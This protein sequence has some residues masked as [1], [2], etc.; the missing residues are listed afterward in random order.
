MSVSVSI[1]IDIPG[2]T[3]TAAAET[4]AQAE[5]LLRT[6]D[7]VLD[8]VGS[9][10]AGE[11]AAMATSLAPPEVKTVV[12]APVKAKRGYR[13]RPVAAT[14]P[15]VS[16]GEPATPAVEQPGAVKLDPRRALIV[17]LLK[18]GPVVYSQVR[19]A[20]NEAGLL[21]DMTDEQATKATGN[22]LQRLKAIG[23]VDRAGQNW[24]QGPNYHQVA[25]AA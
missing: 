7:C 5:H 6:L 18:S 11:L 8:G 4:P 24:I 9:L 22:A 17:K 23:V 20:M 10:P 3:L 25:T 15:A 21:K 12:C 16:H 13:R 1:R 14:T 2:L 19:R